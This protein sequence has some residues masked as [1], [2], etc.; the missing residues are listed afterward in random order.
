M[1]DLK[2][3]IIAASWHGNK[4]AAA[5]LQS[6]IKQ[7]HARYGDKLKINLMSTYP[8]G[9]RRLLPFDFI[10]V[11]PCTPE[12]LVFFAFPL[13]LLYWLFRWLPP[14]KKLLCRNTI[15]KTYLTTDLAIDEAGISFVDSRGFVMNLYAFITCAVPLLLGVPVVK[16][17]QALGEFHSPLNKLLAKIILPKMKLI[18]AR[19]QITKDSLA[20]IG[21]TEN[22]VLCADGAFSMPDSPDVAAEVAALWACDDF[23]QNDV[24]ALSLSSVV[25]SKCEDL[26]IDYRAV[27]TQ[28][29]DA[30]TD[31]GFGVLLIANAAR[32][33]SE[34]NRNND[35]LVCDDVYAAAKNPCKVRWYH[36]EM[37][38]EK[39][40]ELIG[41]SRVLVAAR[42]HAMI[43]ALEKGVPTLLVGWSHKYKEV[44]DMFGLGDWAVDFSHLSC[45]MLLERFDEVLAHEDEIRESIQSHLPEVLK[46]SRQNI[47]LIGDVADGLAWKDADFEPTPQLAEGEEPVEGPSVGKRVA[48]FL[49]RVLMVVAI[50]YI[51]YTVIKF[52][53]DFSVLASAGV[54]LGMVALLPLH[55]ANN[56]LASVYYNQL[57]NVMAAKVVNHLTVVR[58]Y[59]NTFIYRYVPGNIM[60]Y[61][62]R[63]QIA[64]EEDVSHSEVALSTMLE[65]LFMMIAG[66]AI[67]A[68]CVFN[69]LVSYI[70]QIHLSRTWIIIIAVVL[71]VVVLAL[72][73]FRK[74]IR[75]LVRKYVG[76]MKRLSV[77]TCV[78][79]V[80]KVAGRLLVNAVIYLCI[81]MLMG[82]TMTWELLPQV[83]GLFVMSWAIGFVT[84]GA[85]AGLGVREAIML[86]FLGGVLDQNILTTSA[87][88]YRLF[89]IVGDVLALGLSR[90]YLK[91]RARSYRQT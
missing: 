90:V 12:A 48:N 37:G 40:R 61:V 59:C 24:I 49:G 20:G 10:R 43:G 73:L 52:D 76:I 78:M 72:V 23:Y 36:E 87:I 5:M 77:K 54:I 63:N 27:M 39:I 50:A 34:K 38:P 18:C 74:K 45:D 21:I 6:S 26:K 56:I 65:A 4:G 80:L 47:V 19:G 57:L 86:M 31:R 8:A 60:H 58:I 67:A 88:V 84:P 79:Y 51:I 81:V 17:S 16:Y 53:I 41:R 70:G 64:V 55:A 1:N 7:L 85:P 13:A 89:C 15:L 9:D 68:I 69:Y 2:V 62:A 75:K 32:L 35:L 82:Q 66:A 44:L 42:F 33:G 46:S 28:F 14:M 71:A 25:A 30:L 83:V 29:V 22:V 11:V 91:I 3:A